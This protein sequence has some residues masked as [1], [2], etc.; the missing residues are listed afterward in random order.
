MVKAY[1]KGFDS[2]VDLEVW[3]GTTVIA[4]TAL[5][6]ASQYT[7]V[8]L[9]F[10]CP[11]SG[12]LQVRW[13]A[14]ANAAIGYF[15]EV[16]LGSALNVFQVSQAKVVATG[17]IAN[18]TGCDPTNS[19]STLDAHGTDVDCPGVT[20]EYNPGPET[21]QTTDANGAIFT[22]NNL[23]PG[24]Y[25]VE[26]SATFESSAGGYIS[27]AI[28]DGTT[29]TG[30]IGSSPNTTTVHALRTVAFFNYSSGGNKT[31]TLFTADGSGTVTLRNGSG[32]NRINFSITRWPTASELAV[33]TNSA[34]W[35]IDA[36]ISGAA[37]VLSTTDVAS[38]TGMENASLTLTNN[39]Q[40]TATAQI[41]CSSTNAPSG[42]TC[43]SGSE[44]LG[45]VFT[46]PRA[47][48]YRACA[49]FTHYLGMNS[50]G[51]GQ[52]AFQIVETATNAQ[53]IVQEGN[54]RV[55]SGDAKGGT[56]SGASSKP[57][58]VC[59]TFRFADTAARALRVMYEFDL[60]SGTS[61][62]HQ[63][64]A[65]ASSSVGQ[66]DF[67]MEVWPIDQNFAAPVLVGSVTS[68]SAG[69]ERIE[70]IYIASGC[71]SSPCTIASQS[72]VFTSVTRSSAGV[73]VVNYPSA[74]WSS[75]P[76][77]VSALHNG[78]IIEIQAVPS[79][80]SLT[81]NTKN[82]GGT[83]IDAGFSLICMGPR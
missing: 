31:F 73:F 32:N 48:V 29:T 10:P 66:R 4:E 55:N 61:S 60:I 25:R 76:T 56:D 83:L 75:A 68:N 16:H 63:I 9:N 30:Q 41:P 57:V 20:V 36:N 67:H 12:T 24:L 14:N 11:T 27:A 81:V 72:G 18:T 62:A 21:L 44:S 74:T 2:N 15:D 45:V 47:G 35:R 50:G 54:E 43:S 5:T 1:Y 65:D 70:R 49:A 28:N 37:V 39:S 23:S 38:Y 7:P 34:A 77:C 6:A 33:N 80:T 82:A 69:A 51:Q 19:G 46:P 78:S 22:V 53:S 52:A 79:T 71:N 13:Y 3:N 59:G 40:G 58:R 17:H 64:L 26:I 42:T 8:Q